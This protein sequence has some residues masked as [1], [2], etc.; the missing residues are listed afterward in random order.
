MQCMQNKLAFV[1]YELQQMSEIHVKGPK[2]PV[3][4]FEPEASEKEGS[5]WC[6]C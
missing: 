1:L 2:E 5:C 6:F 3:V 4:M